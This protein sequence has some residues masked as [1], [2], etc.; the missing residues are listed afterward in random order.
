MSHGNYG[1]RQE[2]RN[3]PV[4]LTCFSF[5]TKNKESNVDENVES[6]TDIG[7]LGTNCKGDFERI[8]SCSTYVGFYS[9]EKRVVYGVGSK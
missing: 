8:F 6:L 2:N 3:V 5:V 7:N 1:F 9:L 4:T